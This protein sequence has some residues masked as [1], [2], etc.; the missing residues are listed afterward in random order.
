MLNFG[1]E[2]RAHW[3]TRRGNGFWLVYK[4]LSI[5]F[6]RNIFAPESRYGVENSRF[7]ESK[8]NGLIANQLIPLM[9]IF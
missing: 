2:N 6:G 7:E 4:D 5:D 8:E 1:F 3:P 9:L